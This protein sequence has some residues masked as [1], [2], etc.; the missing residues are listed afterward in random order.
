MSKPDK[1]YER[2]QVLEKSTRYKGFFQLDRYR[3]RYRTFDGGWSPVQSRE[4]FERGHAAAILLYDPGLDQV[5]LVEQFRPGAFAAGIEP[6]LIEAV[7]GMIEDGEDL[8]AVAIREAREESGSDVLEIVRIGTFILSP[9]GCSERVTIYCGR[10]D[11][12]GLGGIHGLEEEGEDI[13]VH[14]MPLDEALRKLEIGE[15]SAAVAAIPLQWLALNR[16]QLR[17]RWR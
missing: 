10:V 5:V 12:R 8:E 14:V 3:L 17:Q 13:A 1:G 9:G 16:E 6:W 15:I 7:A 11:S 2:V 4:V